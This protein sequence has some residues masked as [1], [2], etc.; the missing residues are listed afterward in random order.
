MTKFKISISFYIFLFIH[1]I[2][3][4][5]IVP[6]LLDFDDY[7]DEFG[8]EYIVEYVDNFEG[9][10]CRLGCL[11]FQSENGQNILIRKT[12]R[13]QTPL[14]NS[15]TDEELQNNDTMSMNYAELYD[16]SEPNDPCDKPLMNCDESPQCCPDF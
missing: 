11:K 13:Q 9:K 7:G 14:T 10:I 6:S 2:K 8:D 4:S 15:S 12:A 3:I 5:V 1:L 16:Y